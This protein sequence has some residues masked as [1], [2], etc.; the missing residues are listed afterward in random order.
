MDRALRWRP[1]SKFIVGTAVVI[2]VL[3]SGPPPAHAGD[4]RIP[5]VS[6]SFRGNASYAPTDSTSAIGPTRFI[7]ISNS[8]VTIWDRTGHSLFSGDPQ[9]LYTSAG[10]FA[11]AFDPQMIWDPQSRRFYFTA[12]KEA[13]GSGP[14]S[15][16]RWGFSRTETPNGPGD[17]CRYFEPFDFVG[18]Y[19]DFPHLGTTRDFLL[20]GTNRLPNGTGHVAYGD[21][22][23]LMW[24]SKPVHGAACPPATSF[25]KGIV[26]DLRGADHR[27]AFTPMPARQ[28][29]SSPTGWVL[30]SHG[31]SQ[32]LQGNTLSVFSV[33]KSRAGDALVG[34]PWALPVR[35][36]E[37]PDPAPQSGTGFDGK[38]APP[39]DTLDGRLTQAI[40]AYDPRF[41][42]VDLWTAHSVKGGAGSEVRWYEIDPREV[43][44][45]QSGVLSDP[46]VFYYNATIS[47]DRAVD[48][49]EGRF[50]SNMVLE[51]NASSATTPISIVA[52]SK[53]G[54]DRQSDLVTIKTSLAG[55][56]AQAVC[57][58]SIHGCNWGD[59]SG[60]SPDPLGS[61]T[62][63]SGRVWG[64]NMWVDTA[65]FAV[66]WNFAVAPTSGEHRAQKNDDGR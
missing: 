14:G 21:Q 60:T 2:A 30:A 25:R 64:T 3:M 44:L 26:R 24:M 41:H 27:E 19:P 55:D 54:D 32:G 18:T 47:P 7:E 43:E 31:S 29:D 62:R 10:D 53:R 1:H 11:P 61:P 9:Q 23:D 65:H 52:V 57:A 33:T 16:L 56:E 35:P 63:G 28:V 66:S 15:G 37:L 58:G 40:A 45:D 39:V 50:G 51:A 46:N 34:G 38:P 48:D 13:F 36:F 6:E 12:A 8:N 4:V 42:R 59:Y 49:S 5:T 17:W 20:V 22:S